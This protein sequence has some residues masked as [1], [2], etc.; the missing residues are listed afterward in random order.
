MAA[1]NLVTNG[2]FSAGNTG[3]SSQYVYTSTVYYQ[4][5]YTIG[6]QP[7]YNYNIYWGAAAN[8]PPPA[9]AT[10]ANM[11]IINGGSVASNI[12]W[13]ESGIAV[14]PNTTYYFSAQIAN[15]YTVSPATLDFSVNGSPLGSTFT[16]GAA[17]GAWGPFYATWDSGANTTVQLGLVDTNTAGDGNDFALDMIS[18]STDRPGGASVG[19]L[20]E[21]AGWTMLLLGVGAVGGTIRRRP[22]LAA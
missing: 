1:P 7:E 3:F 14:K 19:G 2:D 17:V 9:G 13:S 5:Q 18:L 8:F 22:R 16:A 15:L 21:P 20:P 6:T 10:S 4:G 11:M 12:V